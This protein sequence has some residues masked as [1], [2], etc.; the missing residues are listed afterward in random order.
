MGDQVVRSFFRYSEGLKIGILISIVLGS[1]TVLSSIA[2]MG[3]SAYLIILAGFHPSIALLQVSIVGVRFFGLSRSILRYLER[4]QTHNINIQLL[5]KLRLKVFSKMTK[6]FQKLQEKFSGSNILT[7]IIHDINNLENLFVRLLSPALV[8]LVVSF[9]VG[10]YVGSQAI[11]ILYL[12]LSGFLVIGFIFPFVSIKIGQKRK[13]ELENS[14]IKFQA[15]IINFSQF[16]DQAIFFQVE[17][18]LM[19]DLTEKMKEFES[20]LTK[21]GIWQSLI[22]L[23]SFYINQAIFL[24]TLTLAIFLINQGK[25]DVI[26]VGVITL[27]ILS[28]FEAVMN[29]PAMAYLYGDI[30]VSNKRINEILSINNESNI[31]AGENTDEINSIKFENVSFHY[32]GN[33]NHFSLR[34]INFE[35]K[36]GEKIAIIGENGAGKTTLIDLLLGFRI[37]YEGNIFL[38]GQEL[39]SYPKEWLHRKFSYS[40]VDPYIFSTTVR[41]NLLLAKNEVSDEDLINTLRIVSLFSPPTLDLDSNLVE[42][43]ANLSGGEKRKLSIAQTIL[44]DSDI[45]IFDEPYTNLDPESANDIEQ[46]LLTRLFG[47]TI[48]IITHRYINL[49]LF[50]RVLHLENGEI[51]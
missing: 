21:T 49:H 28:S 33:G 24:I 47:K 15:S 34:K 43:G 2:L 38:S 13:G 42:F 48:I 27:I 5:G 7:I 40:P 32:P 11:E 39:R 30:E 12:Y 29:I 44:A 17:S 37:N 51:V 6:N 1:L 46:L 14:Q 50:D 23:F 26:M 3:V 35:I 22:Q 18:K 25:L 19:N 10:L 45:K 4:L 16:I 36:K 20:E 9:L 8:A 41:Q 31:Y